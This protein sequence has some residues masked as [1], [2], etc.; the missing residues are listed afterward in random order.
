MTYF[1]SGTAAYDIAFNWRVYFPL[2]M[3]KIL[4]RYEAT[5]DVA[6]A[7]QNLLRTVFYVGRCAS[8][9]APPAATFH[10][11][12]ALLRVISEKPLNED[13]EHLLLNH[14]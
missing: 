9:P 12:I 1:T 2:S 10:S 6:K 13:Y 3:E 5:D 4:V 14:P 8:S 7:R 11:S